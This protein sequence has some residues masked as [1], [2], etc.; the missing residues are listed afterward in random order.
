[1]LKSLKDIF[2]ISTYRIF[3]FVRL[4]YI[5]HFQICRKCPETHRVWIKIVQN[6]E[7]KSRESEW[8]G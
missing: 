8:P 4:N 5:I 2:P 6:I 7:T 3:N 1:M